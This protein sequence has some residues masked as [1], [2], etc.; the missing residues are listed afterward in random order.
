[1]EFSCRTHLHDT[2]SKKYLHGK[3]GIYLAVW[4]AGPWIICSTGGAVHSLIVVQTHHQKSIKPWFYGFQMSSRHSYIV[5]NTSGACA[6]QTWNPLNKESECNQLQHG[7]GGAPRHSISRKLYRGSSQ[8]P[9]KLAVH[10][11]GRRHVGSKCSGW[12]TWI[13]TPPP[14]NMN[15]TQGSYLKLGIVKHTYASDGNHFISN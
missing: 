1:M 9:D 10:W 7:E 5:Y 2:K 3:L 8:Y 14:K 12:S 11:E 4:T 6:L 13:P 15:A